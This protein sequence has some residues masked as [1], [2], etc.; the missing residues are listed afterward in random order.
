MP[1]YFGPRQSVGRNAVGVGSSRCLPSQR[2]APR[3]E[4]RR[5]CVSATKGDMKA[6]MARGTIATPHVF[7]RRL[8]A[9]SARCVLKAAGSER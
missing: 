2:R 1:S 6:E 3:Y 8:F 4:W 7:R 5:R 9:D